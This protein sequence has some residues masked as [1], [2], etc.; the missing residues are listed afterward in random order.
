MAMPADY[1]V[2]AGSQV[3]FDRAET[4]TVLHRLQRTSDAVVHIPG[5]PE[6]D[7]Q[8]RPLSPSVDPTRRSSSK[9]PAQWTSKRP[10]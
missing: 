1:R 8:R 5:D 10:S 4:G 9:P 2:P 6:Y 7:W 3:S